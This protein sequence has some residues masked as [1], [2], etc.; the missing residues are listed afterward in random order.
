[1]SSP[2]GHSQSF[3]EL[4]GPDSDAGLSRDDP[5]D[6]SFEGFPDPQAGSEVLLPSSGVLIR[7]SPS[8]VGLTESSRD[9]VAMSAIVPG[10]RLRMCSL[11]LRFNAAGPFLLDGDLVSWDD[12]CLRDLR[13]WSNDSHLLVGLS[14]GD[15]L[16]DLCFFSDTSDQGWGAALSDL[17]L[18]G[19]WSPLCSSFS[20]N[21]RELLAILFAIQGFLPHLRGQTVAVYSDNSTALAYLRKQG[22]T[23][24]S[25][26]NAVAQELLRLCEA[27]SVCLLPQFIPGHLNVLADSLSR[28][29]QV[30]GSEWTLCPQ[31]FAELLRRWPA[32]I[33]FFATSMTHH[34]PVY[35][36]PM[37]D[38]MSVG[39]D[40]MLQSWDGLQAYAFPPF[41]LLPRMLAKV[42]ALGPGADVGGPV[43]ASA[44]VVPGRSRIAPGDPP[45][46]AT[47]EGS[48]Q[49]APLPSLPP[50]PV[51][52]SVNC[53]SYLR[54]SARQAGFSDAVAGQ[55]AHCRRRST[56]VNYQAKWVVYRS[57]CHRHS[58]SV[59][60]PTVAKVAD[61]LLYLCRSL[62][63]SYSSIA[64]YRSMLSQVFR[65]ILPEL[66][67][68][69]VLQDLLRSL[70]L[71]RPLPSSRVPPWDLLVVLQFLCGP[72]FEPLATASMR[73][74]TQKVLFLV[75]LGTA[76]RV[77][78][79][80]AVSR[81]VSFSGSNA[82][83]SY[84]MEFRAKT[85]SAVN[86]LPRSFCVR[87]L[88]DFVGD[89]PDEL[90]LCPVRALRSYLSRT[91]SLMPRPRTL[92]VSP[93][94]PSSSFSKNA[95][96]FFLR[97]VISR[98]YSSSSASSAG[99]SSSSTPS[100][101]RAHSVR[102]VAASWA[103][104]RNASLSSILAAA[105]WSS[106]SVFTSF[107]LSDVQFSS[108]SGFS[109]GPVVAAGSV[110]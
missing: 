8:C 23:R 39:T 96:S 1:M 40:A 25:S 109:L 47:K 73:S 69:F 29:S 11:Q 49:T 110:V 98:A 106:S 63:L 77:G 24:S 27:Q 91:S 78:E 70:R 88:N 82:F 31:A 14:L 72:P 68:H 99:P 42:R 22:G 50:E 2:R 89:H 57:W 30:L 100:S 105:S 56:R 74:L 18:S 75:S 17:H 7:P 76:R 71:E 60:C 108:S 102:G 81:E 36:S 37:Y 9:D 103:F 4:F 90:L 84:L 35:F 80:Q 32:T 43:L 21:Q 107:Y 67:S 26:L 15:S 34:L 58:H 85:E 54:Q 28:R 41:N 20:I 48:A 6:F 45:L 65:F 97:D 87:S 79:L 104:A 19:L 38:P 64:S 12:G 66:S 5:R 16:P 46:P 94:S 93:R 33:D 13:W 10:L 62:S 61:F 51:R 53:I 95:L 3:K 44:P 92:F 83:L 55:L 86:P 52:A 101:S 59:S